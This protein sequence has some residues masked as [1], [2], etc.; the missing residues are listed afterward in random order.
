M[1]GMVWGEL[2][3]GSPAPAGIDLVGCLIVKVRRW[4]PRT[5]GDRP[6]LVKRGHFCRRVPPHPRG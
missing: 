3:L 2:D 6:A 5:R 1:C 4:F